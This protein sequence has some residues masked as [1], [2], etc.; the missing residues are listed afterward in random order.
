MKTFEEHLAD[1]AQHRSFNIVF[2]AGMFSLSN[3]VERIVKLLRD[4]GASFELIGGV[5]VNAHLLAAGERSRMFVTADIDLLVERNE[6][7]EIVRAAEPGGYRAKKIIGGF[8][9]IRPDQRP[10]EAIHMVFAGEKS[11]STQPIS[12]PQVRA[13]EMS[14]F[15]LQVPVA[16]L[17]DLV[18]MK[19]SSLARKTSFISKYWTMPNSLRRTLNENCRPFFM[20]V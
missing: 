17:G 11:K 2:E 20:S 7:S 16:P 14:L 13:E 1:I 18:Q 8:M 4:A 10:A 5:A 6:L 15:E 12:H 9:L 3:D 19:L